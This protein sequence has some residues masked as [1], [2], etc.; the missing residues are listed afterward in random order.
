MSILKKL[1]IYHLKLNLW[2]GFNQTLSMEIGTEGLMVMEV[3]L[4]KLKLQPQKYIYSVEI[5]L[6]SFN[7]YYFVYNVI[8]TLFQAMQRNASIWLH[9]CITRH[10][11]SPNP[12]DKRKFSRRDAM[13]KSKSKCAIYLIVGVLIIFYCLFWQK[14]LFDAKCPSLIGNS[15]MLRVQKPFFYYFPVILLHF[16]QLK[17]KWEAEFISIFKILYAYFIF[18]CNIQGQTGRG[19][20]CPIRVIHSQC[21][22]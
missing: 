12:Q 3:T 7:H 8:G 6:T 21:H 4:W 1:K 18:L 5:L 20:K 17:I 15:E 2:S 13:C 9:T 16:F 19:C 14:Y 11:R 22:F 10:G